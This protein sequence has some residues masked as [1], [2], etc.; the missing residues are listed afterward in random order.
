MSNKTDKT[1]G[2]VKRFKID[3]VSEKRDLSDIQI[4]NTYQVYHRMV[5]F[6]CY[7]LQMHAS[8]M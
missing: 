3:S 1:V 4:A 6:P 2:P 5:H 8:G 7:E